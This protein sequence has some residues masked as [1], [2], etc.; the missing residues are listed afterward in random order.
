IYI[1]AEGTIRC[2]REEHAPTKEEGEAIKA[3]LI[4]ME[5][6]KSVLVLAKTAEEYA[7]TLRGDSFL[8]HT[9]REAGKVSMVR[10]RIVKDDGSKIHVPWTYW[11]DGKWRRTEPDGPLPFWK[12]AVDRK[13]PRFMI[14]EGEKAAL[15]I[16]DLVNNPEREDDLKRHPWA[17]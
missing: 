13:I 7:S 1:D 15:F 11:S 17:D 4:K 8:F 3:A 10:E 9:R 12:P 2:T 6:P 16:D 14:H 5:L